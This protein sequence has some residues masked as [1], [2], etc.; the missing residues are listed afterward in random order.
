MKKFTEWANE[1]NIN[2]V[3]LL[4]KMAGKA[5]N[6]LG[7]KP[8]PAQSTAGGTDPQTLLANLYSNLDF[9]IKKEVLD[10]QWGEKLKA[11]V[12]LI[13]QALQKTN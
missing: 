6:V 10:P 1:K 9:C 4:G 5:M 7:M 8:A 13:Q 3:G 2:E 12:K 11:H